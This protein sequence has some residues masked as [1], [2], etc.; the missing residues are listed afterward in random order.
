LQV[1][2]RKKYDTNSELSILNET[3]IPYS[4]QEEYETAKR[5]EAI[6]MTD[7]EKFTVFCRLMRIGKM[8]STAKITHKKLD[9]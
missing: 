5:R 1:V 3:F 4:R 6:L 8:L 7:E 2:E 9:E